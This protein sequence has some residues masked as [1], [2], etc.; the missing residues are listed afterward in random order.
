MINLKK[1]IASLFQFQLL[2]QN[3]NETDTSGTCFV[4]YKSTGPSSFTKTKTYCKASEDTPYLIHP[5]NLFS[6]T[7]ESVRNA[8]YQLMKDSSCVE[9]L[10]STESHEMTVNIRKE[11]GSKVNTIQELKLTGSSSISPTFGEKL[12]D[13]VQK[14]SDALNL[15]FTHESLMTEREPKMCQDSECPSFEKLVGENLVNIRSDNFGKVKGATGFLRILEG[16]RRAK[17]SEIYKVL[18][19]KI[20]KDIL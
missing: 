5:D 14:M 4:S 16:A 1:G 8:E 20:Y 18:T 3:V 12:E 11:A 9:S 17:K 10:K 19:S 6:I 2:D 13:V 7:V 15:R